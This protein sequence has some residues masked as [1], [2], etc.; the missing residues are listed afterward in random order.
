M[1][2]ILL[3]IIF[4]IVFL[5]GFNVTESKASVLSDGQISLQSSNDTYVYIKVYENGIWWI[6]TYTT[7]GLFVSK[8]ESIN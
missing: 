8:I 1:K 6:Y 7:D 2:K 5:I 4:T 3:T